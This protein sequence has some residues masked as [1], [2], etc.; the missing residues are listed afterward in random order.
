MRQLQTQAH[1]TS[2][3][4]TQE[5]AKW[6]EIH[7][8]G[9]RMSDRRRSSRVVKVAASLAERPG[10]S[11]MQASRSGRF[12]DVKAAYNLFNHP[13]ATPDNLQAPH[14]SHVREEISRWAGS[15]NG[16]VLL[17]E[18]TTELG[19]VGKKP[20]EGLG[21]VGGGTDTDGSQGFHL[22]SVLAVGWPDYKAAAQLTDQAQEDTKHTIDRKR[23][24]DVEVFGLLDQ[25]YYIRK[26]VP[27]EER[28]HSAAESCSRPRE[29]E[30]WPGA[31]DRMG[32]AVESMR[33][34]CIADRGGDIYE[35]LLGCILHG[36]GFVVRAAQDRCLEDPDTGEKSGS[37]FECSRDAKSLGQFT[38]HVRDRIT[39]KHRQVVL[40]A[41]AARI[42]MR[43]PQ[44]LGYT[45]GT[46]L[47]IGCTV[48]RIW[49]KRKKNGTDNTSDCL[50]W[51][52]LT[53]RDITTLPDAKE[54][55]EQYATRWLIEEFHKALKT[56]L[57]AE[58]LQNK[59]AHGLFAAVAI[60]SIIATRL[61]QIREQLR[62]NADAPAT[63]SGLSSLELAL[64]EAQHRQSTGKPNTS[65]ATVQDV[66]LAIGRLG[67]HLNRKNDGHPGWQTLWKGLLILQDMTQGVI[68]AQSLNNLGKA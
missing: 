34:V 29:S 45:Q 17:I 35:Y 38:I 65:L 60:R 28:H 59:T 25:Q 5:T 3:T 55:A 10:R 16:D 58:R 23:R 6:A 63:K 43:S 67:G 15:G 8:G 64:L 61:L 26:M 19:W 44:R 32:M 39:S 42:I 1:V 11:I 22:H 7:F 56:G 51:L 62:L 46:L 36:Y 20:R 57:G 52:L 49:E 53:D 24:R 40:C 50:E 30:L 2:D 31:I 14:R 68:L 54:C 48:V 41:S 33:Q 37:L 66:A 12:Y 18:D 47:P 27:T 13:E 9:V 21:P 4:T